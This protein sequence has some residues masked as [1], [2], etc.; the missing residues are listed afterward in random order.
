MMCFAHPLRGEFLR[1]SPEAVIKCR[2]WGPRRAMRG[3]FPGEP[4]TVEAICNVSPIGNLP[5]MQRECRPIPVETP[6]GRCPGEY[7]QR[8]GIAGIGRGRVPSEGK[9]HIAV[10]DNCR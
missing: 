3:A 2:E 4:I 5:V 1:Y 7:R 8:D 6:T 9:H 10:M